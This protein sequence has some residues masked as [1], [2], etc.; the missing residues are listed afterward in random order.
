VTQACEAHK[1]VILFFLQQV[2]GLWGRQ[3]IVELDK[4]QDGK[5]GTTIAQS[6]IEAH[7]HKHTCKISAQEDR[8]RSLAVRGG[9]GTR[10]LV[11][12]KGLARTHAHTYTKMTQN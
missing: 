12:D 6:G 4:N 7:T 10:F 2:Q 11:S 9:R 8:H 3:K 5:P 1:K